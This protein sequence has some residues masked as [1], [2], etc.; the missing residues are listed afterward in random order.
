MKMLR[1]TEAEYR[2]RVIRNV[3]MNPHLTP[4]K[5]K[6]NNEPT[7]IDGIRFDS[8]REAARYCDLNLQ[9]RA[10]LISDLKLQVK[11]E[12]LPKQ[13]DKDANCVCRAIT[14][15]C[16]FQYVENDELICEDVKGYAN[17]RW[18]IKRALMLNRHGILVREV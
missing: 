2:D 3:E 5:R 1:M 10:G 7:I 18:T 8:K 6:Y 17:D 15:K 4:A 13:Y 14:Y 16:D 11:Y 9:Q 12:L